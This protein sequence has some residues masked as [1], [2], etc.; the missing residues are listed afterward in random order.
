MSECRPRG[1]SLRSSG[2]WSSWQTSSKGSAHQGERLENR[3]FTGEA[4]SATQRYIRELLEKTWIQIALF[5]LL[6]YVLFVNNVAT[7]AQATD[8]SILAINISLI[9]SF[10]VFCLEMT[11]NFWT[12]SKQDYLY[13]AMELIGTFSILLEVSWIAAW[14]G[15]NHSIE[16][17]SVSKTAIITSRAGHLLSAAWMEREC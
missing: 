13:M 16:K 7:I 2:L 5:L 1:R 15:L 3:V 14:L 4:R 8:D 11:L 12:A 9:I 6:S 17:E 10:S